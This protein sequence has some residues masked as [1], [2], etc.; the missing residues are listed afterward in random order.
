MN[1]IFQENDEI[2]IER[3]REMALKAHADEYKRIQEN[4]DI[5][6]AKIA[7]I[8]GID[9]QFARDLILNKTLKEIEKDFETLV[10]YLS[11]E[12]HRKKKVRSLT[13]RISHI[14]RTS[15]IV[16]WTCIALILAS[17]SSV[18]FRLKVI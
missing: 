13:D 3:Q 7:G 10:Y 16:L 12:R 11:D 6:T 8:L 4:R 15:H 17:V 18:L 14:D 9:I 5:W 1:D 2:T